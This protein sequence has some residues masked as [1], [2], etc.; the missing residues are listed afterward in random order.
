MKTTLRKI[1]NSEGVILP[2]SLLAVAGLA[3]AVELTVEQGALVLRKPRD[4]RAGWAAA[5]RA[6][7]AAGEDAVAWPGIAAGEPKASR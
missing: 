2:R 1:G 3:D 6:V 4:A 5:S 7:A